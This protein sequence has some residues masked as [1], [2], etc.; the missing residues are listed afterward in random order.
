[1]A[2]LQKDGYTFYEGFFGEPVLGFNKEDDLNSKI[3][4]VLENKI[5]RVSFDSSIESFDFLSDIDFIEEVYLSKCNTKDY[6]KIH[7]ISNLKRLVVNLDRG[8][9]NLDYTK[10]KHL[11]YL[12]IDWYSNFP[13]LSQNYKLK[14][15]LIWKFKPKQKS[16]NV[17]SLP[18]NLEYLHVTESNVLNLEG[19]VNV[20]NIKH[21]ECHYCGKIE[22]LKGV[23]NLSGNL[24]VLVLDYCKKL[25][26]YEELKECVGL[27]KLVLGDCGP[28]PNLKWLSAL[29]SLSHFSFWNTELL[30]GDTNPCFGIDYISFKNRRNYNHKIEEFRKKS[31][32]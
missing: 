25:I 18:V 24:E 20:P 14:D 29:S 23:S 19:I 17:L 3:K 6:S 28:I 27:N 16:F 1:M 13:D 26:D 31:P 9:P 5:K 10:F 12:S 8:E 4:Y 22:S 32:V 2:T 7:E 15:L 21:I 11:E 30:D